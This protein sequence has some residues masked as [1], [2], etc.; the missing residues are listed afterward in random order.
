MLLKL[1]QAALILR[2]SSQCSPFLWSSDSSWPRKTYFRTH[3]IFS[4]LRWRRSLVLK[5]SIHFVFERLVRIPIASLAL[6]SS[7]SLRCT[8]CLVVPIQYYVVR[9]P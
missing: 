7:S 3:S 6:L 2:L 8:S 9:E 1:H 5:Y 4:F